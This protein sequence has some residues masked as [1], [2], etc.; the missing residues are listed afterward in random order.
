M[1]TRMLPNPNRLI[2]TV[3]NTTYSGVVGEAL[4]VDD[5]HVPILTANG[6]EELPPDTTEED[7]LALLISLNLAD[8]LSASDART[9]LGLGTAAVADTANLTSA[10]TGNTIWSTANSAYTTANSAYTQ[11]NTATTNANSAQVTANS[12]W[13]TANTAETT[14]NSAY[15]QANTATTDAANAAVTANT[16]AL[17]STV[18]ALGDQNA[19]ITWD[20]ASGHV[21]RL[22]I[23][24]DL[25]L[26]LAN[27]ATAGRASLDVTQNAGANYV[28]TLNASHFEWDGAAN[29]TLTATNGARDYFGFE[30]NVSKLLSTVQL[31]N[32]G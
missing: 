16:A 4:D 5:V 3:L 1:T 8:L 28:L 10:S 14:G 24:G 26:S 13:T 2:I 25:T 6:W 19:N 12:A 9:N 21:A 31:K 7:P 22:T 15:A 30:C 27:I 23:S 29:Q 17:Q 11:A 32:I 20:L 18:V